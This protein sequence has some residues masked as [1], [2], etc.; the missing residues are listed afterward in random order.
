MPAWDELRRGHPG[1]K[2]PV[3]GPTAEAAWCVQDKLTNG[4]ETEAWI[5]GTDRQLSEGG[6]GE[7][8]RERLDGK[9][10]RD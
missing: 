10:W 1:S 8:C 4:I 5:H 9:R 2:G 3:T 6:D 7:G